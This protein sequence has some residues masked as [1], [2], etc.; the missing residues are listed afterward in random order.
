MVGYWNTSQK[1]IPDI[2]SEQAFIRGFSLPNDESEW[3]DRFQRLSVR[4]QPHRF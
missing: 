3:K 1:A 2:H 4:S